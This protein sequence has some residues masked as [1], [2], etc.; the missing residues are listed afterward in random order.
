METPITLEEPEAGEP[1][2]Q[3]VQTSIISVCAGEMHSVVLKSDGTV[4]AVGDNSWGQCDLSE[5]TDIV[6]LSAS[7][8]HTAGVQSDGS[9]IVSGMSKGGNIYGQC[10]TQDWKDIISVS[11]GTSHIVGLRSDGTVIAIGDNSR[12]AMQR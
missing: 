12:R 5:W 4:Y 2:Q 7:T 6:T 8:A 9:V 1:K 11:L 10:N 3:I